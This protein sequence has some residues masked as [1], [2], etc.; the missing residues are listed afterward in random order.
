M[1]YRN[2]DIELYEYEQQD[3]S[4]DDLELLSVRVTN[5]SFSVRVTNSPAGDQSPSQAERM[6]LPPEL[7]T[8]TRHLRQRQAT[9]D[10]M[11]EYGEALANCLLPP[12]LRQKFFESMRLLKEDEALRLRLK[13]DAWQ[14]V[15]LPWEYLFVPSTTIK[16]IGKEVDGFLAL[17]RRISIV[18]YEYTD[19]PIIPLN[20]GEDASMRQLVLLSNPS[21]TGLLDLELESKSIS[22]TLQSITNLT[23]EFLID[24]TIEILQEVL[25]RPTHIFH[26]AGHGVFEKNLG[27][28]PGS[29]EG[30][31]YLILC[32]SAG[33]ANL[34]PADKLA[35]NLVRCGVRLAFLNAAES[36]TRGSSYRLSG[37]ASALVYAGIPAVIGLN[38]A[39][40]D[41]SALRFSKAF[42]RTLAA[43]NAVDAAVTNGRLAIFNQSEGDNIDWGIPVLY[44]RT[45]DSTIFP[46]HPQSKK[47]LGQRL[48]VTNRLRIRDVLVKHFSVD[49]LKLLCD[50]ITDAFK[51]D[52]IQQR[53]DLE[54]VGG[55]SLETYALNL[56]QHLERRELLSYLIEAVNTQR[57]NLLQPSKG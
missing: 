34:F 30:R 42:Y 40:T 44:L 19:H 47:A 21:D 9:L 36:A 49:E 35:L 50:D 10:K 54:I 53:V 57:P 29:Y 25:D 7:R 14:L 45:D 28:T 6:T 27:V 2:F 38:G 12:N 26:F 24:P 8:E 20:L 23:L 37:V 43:G 5:E 56:I 41:Q 17:D 48:V 16:G 3:N 46:I 4:E 18:R 11:I 32:D 52:G 51:R 55:N 15:D 1:K 22:E 33:M 13:F 31:G 39:V